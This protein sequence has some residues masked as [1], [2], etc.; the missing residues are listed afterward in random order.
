MNISFLQQKNI[1]NFFFE[2]FYNLAF[3]N[4]LK[5]ELFIND[6]F[7]TK[8][9]NELNSDNDDISSL[10]NSESESESDS[11]SIKIENSTNLIN[12]NEYVLQSEIQGKQ[13]SH[14][15]SR[16]VAIN[17]IKKSVFLKKKYKINDDDDIDLEDFELKKVNDDLNIINNNNNNK[18]DNKND[19]KI[20]KKDNKKNKIKNEIIKIE[21]NE[22]NDFLINEYKNKKILILNNGSFNPFINFRNI[23]KK[24][25]TYITLH[26]EQNIYENKLIN[27]IKNEENENNIKIITMN[28]FIINTDENNKF[29]FIII[30]HSSIY[31]NNLIDLL[32]NFYN[33][34]NKNG[35]IYFY[36][37]VCNQH[38]NK[39][40]RKNFIRTNLIKK[41]TKLPIG[42]LKNL[43]EINE[44]LLKI[45]NLYKKIN[46]SL[47]LKKN[48]I[49][50]G[51]NNIFL[52]ILQK[53]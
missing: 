2:N 5:N 19:N 35:K 7:N 36:H 22:Q 33:L 41:I 18:N 17:N 25:N 26:N 8:Q 38:E 39:K 20:K 12:K 50:F 40:N 6:N 9:I 15:N 53:K 21:K 1:D 14:N 13:L 43:V 48:F 27:D 51:E 11:N 29:D 32:K 47:F 49:L 28:P 34:L 42:K 4:L 44:E 31:E 45:E 30:H 24:Y 46:S 23:I 37:S 10:S 16:K 52:F 3:E